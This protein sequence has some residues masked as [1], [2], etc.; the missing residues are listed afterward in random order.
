MR[1]AWD[2][3]LDWREL[4]T[5]YCRHAFGAGAE[6]MEQLFLR[7]ADRQSSAGMEAGSYHAYH[8]I[9]DREWLAASR[10]LVAKAMAAATTD[11]DRTPHSLARPSAA[12]RPGALPRL[13]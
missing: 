13:P 8:L 1:L 10:D 4:L 9:Y 5:S 6:P 7:L 11:D 2:P 12:R 3:S